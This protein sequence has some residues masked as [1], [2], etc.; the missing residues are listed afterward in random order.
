MDIGVSGAHSKKCLGQGGMRRR[1]PASLPLHTLIGIFSPACN[2]TCPSRRYPRA[3][4]VNAG[5]DNAP[6]STQSLAGTEGSRGADPLGHG[7]SSALA[8]RSKTHW[9]P[10]LAKEGESAS[11]AEP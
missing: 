6:F 7:N 9:H 1:V 5:P 4:H 11:A 2:P 3:T 10:E 8:A